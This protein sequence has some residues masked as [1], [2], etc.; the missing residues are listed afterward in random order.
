LHWRVKYCLISQKV[1]HFYVK[2]IKTTFLETQKCPNKTTC[3]V[4]SVEGFVKDPVKKEYY[5][6]TYCDA[7]E[8]NWSNCCRY[9]AKRS[10]NLCPV[11]VM[12]DSELTVDEILDKLE[13]E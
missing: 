8:D 9:I 1:I 12:P 7:G 3:P 10:L 2:A 4:H 6:H 11:F 5:I 13:N